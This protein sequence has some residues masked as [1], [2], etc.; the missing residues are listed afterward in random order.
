MVSQ[1]D[2]DFLTK[3]GGRTVGDEKDK[4]LSTQPGVGE[5]LLK[6]QRQAEE[7]KTEQEIVKK[8]FGI[9]GQSGEGTSLPAIIVTKAMDSHEKAV[10]RAE[11]ATTGLKD[12]IK[13]A[14]GDAAQAKEAL[15]QVQIDQIGKMITTMNDTLKEI[16]AG[17]APKSVPQIINDAKELMA[18]LQPTS[19]QPTLPTGDSRLTLDL[20]TMRQTHEIAM[21]QLDIQLQQMSQAFQLS[22]AEFNENTSQRWAEYKDSK[23]FRA[24]GMEGF[25][26]LIAS[27][28]SSITKERTG[29]SISKERT[30]GSEEPHLEASMSLFP[31]QA[32]GTPI[33][34]KPGATKIKC[35]NE[36]CGA[37]FDIK[38]TAE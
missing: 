2:V 3:V 35:S 29:G 28:G 4:N 1:K 16:K 22:I 10:E 20:Q 19:T 36:D 5:H 9:G 26:D 25:S 34:I 13:T 23:E 14:Q 8:T 11:A 21:K 17:A 30:G 27:V 38:E 31:C 33:E 12:E 32:C 6:I 24:K 37:E 7:Q 15:V 18:T